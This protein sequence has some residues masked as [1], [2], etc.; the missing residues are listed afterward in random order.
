M[1]TVILANYPLAQLD[2]KATP[3]H[4]GLY[5]AFGRVGWAIALCYI[6]FACIHNYGGPINWLLAFPLW[7]PLSRISYA[8]YLLHFP[9][10]LVTMAT[11]KTSLYF[12]ELNA[13]SF[14][15]F[16]YFIVFTITIFL[17]LQFH[18][19]IGNYFITVFVSIVATLAFES[20][21]ITIENLLFDSKKKIHRSNLSDKQI[22]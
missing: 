7:Q 1:A 18:A 5:D 16:E 11:M 3:L 13:V 17:Y 15:Q 21:I 4:Y 14:V 2:S 9:V 19:F 10:I 22:L 6:I 20:P 12:S 8:I